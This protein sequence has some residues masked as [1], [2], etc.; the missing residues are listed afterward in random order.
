M[1]PKWFNLWLLALAA[2]WGQAWGLSP[3]GHTTS[4]L[5]KWM[6]IEKITSNCFLGKFHLAKPKFV[7]GQMFKS[8]KIIF[9]YMV[10]HCCITTSWNT[11]RQSIRDPL[12]PVLFQAHVLS[13]RTPCPGSILSQIHVKE[14][15]TS[16]QYTWGMETRRKGKFLVKENGNILNLGFNEYYLVVY[17][18]VFYIPR[19]FN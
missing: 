2:F 5:G 1:F 9:F 11:A 6:S 10:H 16:L 18:F 3:E 13:S 8:M 19:I 12:N 7:K 4:F 14:K 15:Q 17:D